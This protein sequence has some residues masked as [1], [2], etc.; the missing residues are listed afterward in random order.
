[1]AP[2]D[3]APEV[4]VTGVETCLVV[5]FDIDH[6]LE[7]EEDRVV[8][9]SGCIVADVECN[10]GSTLATSADADKGGVVNRGVSKRCRVERGGGTIVLAT[11]VHPVAADVGA[12]R[13]P[14]LAL[15]APTLVVVE[16]IVI[17]VGSDEVAGIDGAAKPFK[18]VVLVGKHFD[19]LDRRA[20]TDAAHGESI[21]FVIATDHSTAVADRDVADHTRI[22]VIR[23]TKG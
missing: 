17:A 1:V 2:P 3:V 20:A 19:K 22:V 10:I 8:V 4:D 15:A 9:T 16:R 5:V 21:D 11:L 14:E 13:E 12:D 23:A 6:L 7:V 18:S